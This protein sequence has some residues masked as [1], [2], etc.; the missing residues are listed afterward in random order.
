[1]SRWPCGHDSTVTLKDGR[2]VSDLDSFQICSLV[3]NLANEKINPGKSWVAD[4]VKRHFE[5]YNES[6]PSMGCAS[7]RLCVSASLR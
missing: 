4:D 6:R 7:L 5:G 2:C 1:M 3:S